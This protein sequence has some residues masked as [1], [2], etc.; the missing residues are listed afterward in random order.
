MSPQAVLERF[1]RKKALSMPKVQRL[2]YDLVEYIRHGKGCP[3][4][5]LDELWHEM[6]LDTKF[7]APW[8]EEI[9][10]HFVHHHPGVLET[11]AGICD[12]CCGT[13]EI[14]A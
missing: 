2:Y 4:E 6:I 8:C 7:Y 13:R 14:T 3:P 11:G 12:I 5:E 10:G 9:F 1:S